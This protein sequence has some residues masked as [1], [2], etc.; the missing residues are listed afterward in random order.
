[1]NLSAKE[2]GTMMF[3][4]VNSVQPGYI[5]KGPKR[6]QGRMTKQLSSTLHGSGT[7]LDHNL[8]FSSENRENCHHFFFCRALQLDRSEFM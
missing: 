1:M 3:Q 2:K 5:A 7:C 6:L 4:K 8:M